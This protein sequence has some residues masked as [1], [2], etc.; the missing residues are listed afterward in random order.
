MHALIISLF[1][2]LHLHDAMSGRD[3]PHEAAAIGLWLLSGHALLWLIQHLACLHAGG[4][5]DRNGQVSA[6]I[7]AERVTLGVRLIATV[8]TGFALVRLGWLG[9]VRKAVGDFIL[10]DELLAI[11][12]TLTLFTATLWSFEPIDRRLK[13]AV[14][15]RELRTGRP[16]HAPRSRSAYVIYHLRHTMLMILVPLAAI[17][18]WEEA[19]PFLGGPIAARFG[20]S[21]QHA[22]REWGVDVARWGGVLVIFILTPLAIRHIWDTVLLD[23]GETRERAVAVAKRHG[24]RVAGPLLWRTRGGVVNAAILGMVYPFRY[25]LFTDALLENLTREEVEGV[26]AHEI[27]HVRLHHIPWLAITVL[28]AAMSLGWVLTAMDAFFHFNADALELWGSLAALGLTLLTFGFVS[29]RFE[30]QADAFAVKHLSGDA[31]VISSG[32]AE[33]MRSSLAGV[34][35]YNGIN[36]AR[37]TFRHGSIQTRRIRLAALI[38]LPVGTLAIDRQVRVLKVLAAVVLAVSVAV[39]PAMTW[40]DRNSPPRGGVIVDEAVGGSE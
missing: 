2:A 8:A 39:Y 12:P 9:A 19:V 28:A 32:A 38:G 6:L 15:W 31:E 10:L 11:L 34:A 5:L 36:P 25:M 14:L 7:F 27:A 4:R 24:V 16:V 13:E 22:W 20:A 26:I 3:P 17:L 33:A 35:A 1:V 30:W 29:R 18:A 40:L 23:H 37:F 21:V